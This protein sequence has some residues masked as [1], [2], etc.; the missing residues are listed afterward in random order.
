MRLG[1]GRD[2]LWARAEVGDVPPN[3]ARLKQFEAIGLLNS[4]EK[5]GHERWNITIKK[6]GFGPRYEVK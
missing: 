6:A 3:G 2:E 5:V 1:F 4:I